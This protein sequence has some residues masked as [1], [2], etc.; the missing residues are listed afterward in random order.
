MFE[1][2]SGLLFKLDRTLSQLEDVRTEHLKNAETAH[3]EG[4]RSG[5]YAKAKAFGYIISQLAWI[6]SRNNDLSELI[7]HENTTEGNLGR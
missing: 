1:K 6:R 2:Y 5:L 7:K 4:K 3:T